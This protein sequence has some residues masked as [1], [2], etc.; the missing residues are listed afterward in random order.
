MSECRRLLDEGNACYSKALTPGL[1]PGLHFGRLEDAL[2]LYHRAHSKAGNKEELA[3]ACK[4]ISMCSWRLSVLHATKDV[5]RAVFHA[6]EGVLFLLEASRLRQWKPNGWLLQLASVCSEALTT[7]VKEM[8][9]DDARLDLLRAAC[10]PLGV[11]GPTF[12]CK[13]L[14]YFVALIWL[15][16]ARCAF[17]KSLV[18]ERDTSAKVCGMLLGEA[19]EG[20]SFSLSSL[21]KA[22]E[23]TAI[24]KEEVMELLRDVVIQARIVEAEASLHDALDHF[25]RYMFDEDFDMFAI[26]VALDLFQKVLATSGGLAV[27]AEAIA[28]ARMGQIFFNVLKVQEK[29]HRFCLQAV[30][31]AASMHPKIFNQCDWYQVCVQIIEKWRREKQIEEEA[32]WQKKREPIMEKL[33]PVLYELKSQ[34]SKPIAFLLKFLFEKHPPK[35]EEAVLGSVDAAA[36]KNTLLKAIRIYHPDKNPRDVHGDEWFVLCEEICKILNMKLELLKN[37][38]Q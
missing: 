2:R 15:T 4:N 12:D 32:G 23:E 13:E 31:L 19:E 22:G 1:A 21:M 36:L 5:S 16:R 3:S 20:C 30:Q 18:V 25:K 6:R 26:M 8:C 37:E 35:D 28:C 7:T 27:E 24:K 9:D 10:G 38:R 29:G 33:K 17:H 11:P 34:A 14:A